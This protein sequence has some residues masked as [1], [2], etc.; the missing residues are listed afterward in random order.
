MLHSITKLLIVLLFVLS[1]SLLAMEKRPP[2]APWIQ[3]LPKNATPHVDMKKVRGTQKQ[4]KD[5]VRK[6]FQRTGTKFLQFLI[7]K[8]ARYLNV[9]G[10]GPNLGLTEE[11]LRFV[12]STKKLPFAFLSLEIGRILRII[13]ASIPEIGNLPKDLIPIFKDAKV[14][15]SNYLETK[16]P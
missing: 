4:L 16:E 3:I 12:V 5:R 7:A 15:F 6:Q 14:D 1:P 10:L 8:D 9:L 13:K 2:R 11:D